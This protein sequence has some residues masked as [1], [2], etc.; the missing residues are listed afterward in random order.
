MEEFDQVEKQV[1]DKRPAFVSLREAGILLLGKVPD[2]DMNIRGIMEREL[3]LDVMFNEFK[4]SHPDWCEEDGDSNYFVHE[5]KF[6]AWC[7]TQGHTITGEFSVHVSKEGFASRIDDLKRLVQKYKYDIEALSTKEQPDEVFLEELRILKGKL[8]DTEQQIRK[9]AEVGRQIAAADTPEPP[10][11]DTPEPSGTDT[12]EPPGTDTPEPP[13]TDVAGTG[14]V[15]E[16]APRPPP[17]N[18]PTKKG[19]LHARVF[20]E[21]LAHVVEHGGYTPEQLPFNSVT[22]IDVFNSTVDNKYHVIIEDK[23]GFVHRNRPLFRE[24]LGGKDFTFSKNT[25][26][27]DIMDK[28]KK[29]L[30]DHPFK[31][32]TGHFFPTL[33][34]A[35]TQ[36]EFLSLRS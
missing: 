29:I 5:I 27:S 16:E 9:L 2:G 35:Q 13:G 19:T 20:A 15:L 3:A 26:N 25:Q 22:L 14:T 10:G 12:P 24:K 6:C 32:T 1:S 7:V 30:A 18:K 21:F 33:L 11:T 34:T 36:P 28:I 23:L 4:N 8:T 31:F 17:A